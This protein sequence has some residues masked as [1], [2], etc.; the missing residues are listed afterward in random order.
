MKKYT[1]KDQ[2]ILDLITKFCQNE[3]PSCGECPEDTCVLFNIE[4]VIV[5]DKEEKK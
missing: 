3:C 2:Q 5:K 4:Q 1:K